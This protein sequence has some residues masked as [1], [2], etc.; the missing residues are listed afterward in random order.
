MQREAGSPMP[1][2]M[3][4]IW[5]PRPYLFD[6]IKT[7]QYTQAVANILTNLSAHENASDAASTRI[8][9]NLAGVPR[10]SDIIYT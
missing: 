3:R 8:T 6:T 5:L 7:F 10:T 2:L 1:T 9:T 4:A